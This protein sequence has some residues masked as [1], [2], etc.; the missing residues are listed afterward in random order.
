MR[1]LSFLSLILGPARTSPICQS[2]CAQQQTGKMRRFIMQMIGWLLFSGIV[3]MSLSAQTV[4]QMRRHTR[5][6][7]TNSS[8]NERVLTIEVVLC[9]VVI[10]LYRNGT[11]ITS[12]EIRI[13]SVIHFDM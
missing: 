3:R 13:F 11:Q 2:G 7:F 10:R 12:L 6:V 4:V 9:I 8:Y 1:S 5:K